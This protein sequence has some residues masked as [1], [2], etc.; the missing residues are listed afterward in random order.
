MEAQNL[1]QGR[2]RVAHYVTGRLR[3][4]S[5]YFRPLRQYDVSFTCSENREALPGAP[6]AHG[7]HEQEFTVQGG[8]T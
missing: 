3:N 8:S 6:T 2:A 5:H 4:F 1:G 7:V